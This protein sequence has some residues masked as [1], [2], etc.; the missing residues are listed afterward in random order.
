[1]GN[2]KDFGSIVEK[3]VNAESES[4][5]D[6]GTKTDA[7]VANRMEITTTRRI[8]FIGCGDGGCNIGTAVSDMCD[9]DVYVI[10]YNT[11]TR[12]ID[13][14]RANTKVYPEDPDRKGQNA[15]GSGR[16]RP[17]AKNIFKT[18]MHRTLLNKVQSILE[19]KPDIQY[20]IVC[21][22]SDG[23][24]GSGTVPMAA[25]LIYDTCKIPTIIMGV[26]PAIEEGMVNQY[27]ALEWQSEVEKVGIPYVILDNR[28]TGAVSRDQV[29][30]LHRKVNEY[31]ARIVNLLAGRE[32]GNTNISMID[33][34]NLFM[35]LHEI[36]GRIVVTVDDTR[37]TSGQS[38]DDYVMA[39]IAASYQ[40]EPDHM[41]GIGVFIKG[42]QELL[43]RMDGTVP[44]I[45]D[46]YGNV[47]LGFQHLELSEE[48]RI[49]VIMTGNIE[50]R[51]RLM[52]IK[53]RYDDIQDAQR[54]QES[55]TG[56][57]MSGIS[58]PFA[59]GRRGSDVD[60]L[61]L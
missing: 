35:L 2:A 32:Y 34:R 22:T 27:N 39:S 42:P 55:V 54:A 6:I 45:Q 59:V 47:V 20:V 36:G 31:A 57:I 56:S 9:D 23:G 50:P 21:G 13:K 28:Q 40:P 1:M 52:E 51:N 46:R 16:L 49:S 41:K 18:N 24:T 25:K 60:A 38:L 37:P 11:T 4:T 53:G 58:N 15:D 48:T 17:Y 10:A 43:D 8:L 26:Y 5:I 14:H 30:V 61:D 33:N 12:A 19:A 7:V 29:P 44:G 3:T